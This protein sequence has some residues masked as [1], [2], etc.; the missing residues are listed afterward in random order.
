MK[1]SLTAADLRW[2]EEQ[3]VAKAR[4]RVARR[5]WL[6]RFAFAVMMIFI[7][8]AVG[9]VLARMGVGSRL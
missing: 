8:V 4:G 7:A 2:E 3:R 6:L 1:R 5:A 9:T